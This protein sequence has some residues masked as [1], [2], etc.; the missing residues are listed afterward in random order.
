M[1]I[2]ENLNDVLN[3]IDAI[4]ER[5]ELE[6]TISLIAV[7]KTF[8]ADAVREAYQAGQRIFGEN[9]VQEGEAKKEELASLTDIDW[10]LIGPLQSNKVRKAVK[11]FST[12]HTVD[13][14]KLAER[15]SRIAGEETKEIDVLIQVNTS[16]ETS[17]SGITPK[18]DELKLLAEKIIELPHITLKGLM[19]IGPLSTDET[20]I[21][22]SFENLR[23]LRNKLEKEL[24]LNLP[25]LSMGMS[26]DFPIA[27]KQG[28]TLLRV[29][30]SIFGRR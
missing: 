24:S 1:S 19:T 22:E 3:Q 2:T 18:L 4:K 27:M 26:G 15:I 28:A 29:G 21:K 25:E 30:S 8:P 13:S 14:E 16:G 23:E 9:K 6:Q 7:S 17:K 11:T 20:A 5:E 12:I 10:H